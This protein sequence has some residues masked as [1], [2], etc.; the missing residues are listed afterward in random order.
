[1]KVLASFNLS[2]NQHL[3]QSM[4]YPSQIRQN[5]IYHVIA[6]E[7]D[8]YRVV[9][10]NLDNQLISPVFFNVIEYEFVSDWQA[11]INHETFDFTP[12]IFVQY[13]Y[14][15]EILHDGDAKNSLQY[16]D[17]YMAYLAELMGKTTV[18]QTLYQH[19]LTAKSGEN[20]F[21]YWQTQWLKHVF[22]V[23]KAIE[24]RHFEATFQP[25]INQYLEN[26]T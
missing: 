22:G 10:D 21:S 1:M 7:N 4:I 19:Y 24:L 16:A 17:I 23:T 3:A 18:S 9:G 8:L 6:I 20:I 2:N 25:K 11:T 14:F 5:S 15:W 26:L 13:P 12:T